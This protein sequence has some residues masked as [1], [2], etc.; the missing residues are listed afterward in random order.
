MSEVKGTLLTII[1]V[2][3]VFASVFSVIT[4]AIERKADDVANKIDRTGEPAAQAA[5]GAATTA[6]SLIYHY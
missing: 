1:L 6:N 2:L 4:L 3:A 5:A